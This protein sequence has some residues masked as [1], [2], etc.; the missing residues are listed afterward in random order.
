MNAT[1]L[2]VTPEEAA[3]VLAIGRTFVYELLA[4]G[5]IESIKLGRRRLIPREALD[6][7]VAEERERQAAESGGL[8]DD[9]DR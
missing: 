8:G 2:C 4:S 7:F 6:R 1:P 3:R 9:R 5:R